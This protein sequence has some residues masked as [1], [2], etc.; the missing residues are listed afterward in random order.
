MSH[1]EVDQLLREEPDIELLTV[2]EGEY[3]IRQGEAQSDVFLVT[4]GAFVVEQAGA[5]QSKGLLGHLAA[6]MIDPDNPCF[7]G[8]M[9]W[10]GAFARTA[11]VRSSGRLHALRLKPW[12]MEKILSGFPALTRSM[13]RQFAERLKM[14]NEQL[15]GFQADTAM[16]TTLIMKKPGEVVLCGGEPARTLYQ[17]VDGEVFMEGVAEP[18]TPESLPDGF[19]H[20]H[21]YLVEGVWPC[22]VTAASA[23]MLVA[24]DEA[25]RLAVVRNYPRAVLADVKRNAG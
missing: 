4:S 21:A 11:S 1:A 18:V 10:L 20:L 25:S 17:L 7:V 15:L 13:C 5:G 16:T 14:T 24:I 3:L 6:V 8:E 22:T 19:I 2:D 23:A 9:A 12:H